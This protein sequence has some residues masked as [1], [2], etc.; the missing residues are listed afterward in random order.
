MGV[1][2]RDPSVADAVIDSTM[3]KVIVEEVDLETLTLELG[4]NEFNGLAEK[5]SGNVAEIDKE[6]IGV[7][8]AV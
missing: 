2:E 5:L 4:L 8:D 6:V 1:D 3:D 7:N